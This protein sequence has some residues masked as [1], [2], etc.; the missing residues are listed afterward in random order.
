MTEQ[1]DIS[2]NLPELE[3]QVFDAVRV[4]IGAP[5]RISPEA[6]YKEA[7]ALLELAVLEA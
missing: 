6:S 2:E 7:V 4:T 5:V 1:P 3:R